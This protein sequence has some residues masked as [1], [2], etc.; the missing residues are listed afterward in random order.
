MN[1]FGGPHGDPEKAPDDFQAGKRTGTELTLS[2]FMHKALSKTPAFWSKPFSCFSDS[3]LFV[4]WSS[5]DFISN[6]FSGVTDSDS[7]LVVYASTHL[8]LQQETGSSNWNCVHLRPDSFWNSIYPSWSWLVFGLFLVE[9]GL[10]H[11][12]CVGSSF[13]L[14]FFFF[15]Q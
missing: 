12:N 4:F 10:F 14:I 6:L 5:S 11:W 8:V 13:S 1:H 3:A 9:H 2:A 7:G 15:L